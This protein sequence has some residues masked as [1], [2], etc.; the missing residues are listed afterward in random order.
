M[1]EED[2]LELA[3]D[4][5]EGSTH[6]SLKAPRGRSIQ[7]SSPAE[8]WFSPL[9]PLTP[10]LSTPSSTP[11]TPP[12]PLT[13]MPQLTR[14]TTTPREPGRSILP[15]RATLVVPLHPPQLQPPL[16]LLHLP[17]LQLPHLLPHLLLLP[18]PPRH[19]LPHPLLPLAE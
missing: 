7:D 11:P 10:L 2:S 12:I 13:T 18:H 3:A 16:P 14:P 19:L 15:C 17:Q 5:E 4:S 1:P 6:S 9:P 8:E